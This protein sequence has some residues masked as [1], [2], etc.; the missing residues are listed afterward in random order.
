MKSDT[1]SYKNS[2]GVDDVF[3]LHLHDSRSLSL[4]F[5]EY[6]YN[7]K[8]IDAI[9]TSP[10]YYNIIS[11]GEIGNQVGYGQNYSSYLHDIGVIFKQLFKYTKNNGS[12]WIIIDTITKDKKMILLP[13][14]VIKEVQKSGWILKDIIIWKKDRTRPWVK[15]G[16][17][18]K[19]FEYILFFVKSDNYTYYGDRIREIELTTFKEWW[20]K[21]PERYNPKG[22]FPTNIWEFPIPV[23]GEW[24][25]HIIKH[26]NPLPVGLIKRILLLT[27]NEQS[28]VCDPFSGSGM[29]LAVAAAMNRRYIGFE[30]NSA[31]V[32]NFKSKVLP[33]VLEN[34]TNDDETYNELQK[35]VSNKIINLRVIKIGK[36]LIKRIVNKSI[37]DVA[38]IHNLNSIFV[39]KQKGVIKK[40]G[41]KK[42][43]ANLLV[44]IIMNGDIPIIKTID[45]DNIL[46]EREITRYQM[47]LDVKVISY[48][49]A[50]KILEKANRKYYWLY[51]K[52]RCHQYNKKIHI[53]D[54]ISDSVKTDWFNNFFDYIPP[55]LSNVEVFE[56]IKKTWLS[57]KDKE[58]ELKIKY[59]L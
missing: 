57:K 30:L 27:T 5:N 14:D 39:I 25:G 40:I 48:A 50:C 31:Y 38:H 9:I 29:V 55:I 51:I 20:I 17:M 47:M 58:K 3:S 8:F 32:R 52:A 7:K 4:K 37:I 59:N 54:W 35:K 13:H 23:Q 12:L 6:K 42:I 44:Y 36:T 1:R 45:I 41:N 2:N 46:K 21:Y 22:K 16:Q 33:Y 43:L 56:N 11:Y 10:P 15:K 49:E 34:L 18:R 53:N 19:I 26:S 28:V 24:G